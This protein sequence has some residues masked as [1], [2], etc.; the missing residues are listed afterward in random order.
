MA[1]NPSNL[2]FSLHSV[3]QRRESDDVTKIKLAKLWD[4]LAYFVRTRFFCFAVFY[5]IY[6]KVQQL[7]Q[8]SHS[9]HAHTDY[10]P[11]RTCNHTILTTSAYSSAMPILFN[12]CYSTFRKKKKLNKLLTK[13]T[14]IKIF[15]KEEINQITKSTCRLVFVNSYSQCRSIFFCFMLNVYSNYK[16]VYVRK[17]LI[18]SATP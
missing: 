3:Q 16:T 7:Q 18:S 2:S 12:K 8:L 5:F 6:S 10:T 9:I 1:G 14:C 4:L 13:S 11:K 15:V 17:H